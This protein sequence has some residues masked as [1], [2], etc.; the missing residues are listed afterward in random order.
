MD[1]ATM[2]EQPRRSISLGSIFFNI[3]SILWFMGIS[4]VS[5]A[6]FFLGTVACGNACA[7]ISAM[8]GQAITGITILGV[9]SLFLI[10][11]M[12]AR[13][14]P[15]WLLA[16]TAIIDLAMLGLVIWAFRGILGG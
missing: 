8:W 9:Y 2:Q 5:F 16:I 1:T 3:F 4:I 14:M 6:L 13:W 12:I 11:A 7:E 15:N 10:G